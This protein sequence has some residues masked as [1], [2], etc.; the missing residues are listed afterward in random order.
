VVERGNRVVRWRGRCRPPMVK[1]GS[2]EDPKVTAESG[3][4][5]AGA[6]RR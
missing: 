4:S 3:V 2:G 1:V 5:A 6:M